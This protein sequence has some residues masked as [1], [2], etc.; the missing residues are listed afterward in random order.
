VTPTPDVSVVCSTYQR[1]QR[2]ASLLAAIEA[3]TYPHDKFEVV[4]VDDGSTD[5]TSEY[6]EKFAA[7]SSLTVRLVSLP[8]NTG[9]SAGRNTGWRAARGRVIAFTDDDCSPSPDWLSAGMAAMAEGATIVVGRTMPNPAQSGNSGPFSRTQNVDRESGT[10][11]MHTCNVF[12]LRSDLEATGGFD[13][14][15]NKKGGEDTDLGWRLLDRGASVAFAEDAV[16][17]HDV[18]KG[19]FRAAVRE[20][21]MW[22]DIPRVAARHPKRARPLLVHGL[23]WKRSHEYVLLAELGVVVAVVLRNPLPLLA[24]APWLYWRG[25]R[26]PMVRGRRRFVYLPHAFVIDAVE[27]VTMVRGSARSKTLVL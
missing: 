22:R 26:M 9:R 20:A 23:F 10:R 1:A 24:F 13:P 8:S 5:G 2:L 7:D 4:I 19:S 11:Y 27:V 15:F 16:V 14:A 21:S 17:L 3:Q 6:V 18:T 12:Y 25:K